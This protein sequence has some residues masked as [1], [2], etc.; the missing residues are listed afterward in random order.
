MGLT[1]AMPARDTWYMLN[2]K[3]PRP[4]YAHDA[5]SHEDDIRIEQALI[6]GKSNSAIPAG[7]AWDE[8]RKEVVLPEAM[9]GYHTAFIGKWHVGRIRCGG[10][11]ARRSGVSMRCR[12]ISMPE[13]RLISAGEGAGMT[14]RNGAH[15]KMPQLEWMI[16]DAGAES[17]ESYL[18]DD[19]TQKALDYI[20]RRV[21]ADDGPFFLYFC[22]FA[23]HTP[24]QAK[25]EDI[26]YFSNKPTR[27]W[28][29]R[30]IR[31]MPVWCA[32]STIPV[33]KILDKLEETGIEENTLVVFL[34]DTGESTEDHAHDLITNNSPYTGERLHCLKAG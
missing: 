31:S 12:L 20:D 25:P 10:V 16:G 33:G 30:A 4:G 34:S 32:D 21:A 26:E 17:G 29:R 8:G 6:N 9:E 27:G 28:N 18:T 5:I 11:S 1:T 3:T 24:I 2:E 23:V 22:E 7:L 13:V 19:L 14:G 15:P